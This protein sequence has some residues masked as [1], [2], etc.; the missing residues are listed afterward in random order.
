MPV[1]ENKVVYGLENAH[2]AKL[3]FGVGGAP[4]FATPVALKGSVE[5]KMDPE[6][7]SVEFAA[8]NDSQYLQKTKTTGTAVHLLSLIC[9]YLSDKIFL[10]RC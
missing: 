7:N 3:T 6:T 9:L 10:A 4:T 5:F 8:D 2:Y 1:K